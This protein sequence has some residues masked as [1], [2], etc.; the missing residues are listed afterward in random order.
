[1]NRRV[2]SGREETK[3]VTF[4][5]YILPHSKKYA[6]LRYCRALSILANFI[7]IPIL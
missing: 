1:M 4:L 7:I 3:G 6:F 5:L 2:M